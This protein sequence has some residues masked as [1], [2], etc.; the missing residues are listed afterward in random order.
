MLELINLG[1]EHRDDVAKGGE[2][3]SVSVEHGVELSEQIIGQL[4]GDLGEFVVHHVETHEDALADAI[5]YLRHIAEP[6]DSTERALRGRRSMTT[7][8]DLRVRDQGT[9]RTNPPEPTGRD[10]WSGAHNTPKKWA[11]ATGFGR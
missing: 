8:V 7:A 10:A 4:P 11:A 9:S 2:C 1:R 5:A 6:T 3:S